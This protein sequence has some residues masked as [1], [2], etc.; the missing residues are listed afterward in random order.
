MHRYDPKRIE[1]SQSPTK[2]FRAYNWGDFKRSDQISEEQ[3]IVP[4]TQQAEESE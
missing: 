1:H 2:F 4:I 3:P